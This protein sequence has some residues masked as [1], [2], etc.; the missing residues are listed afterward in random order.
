MVLVPHVI[1]QN[2]V[3]EG[4]RDFMVWSSL[5]PVTILP[6]L[7]VFHVTLQ[8]HMIKVEVLEPFKVSKHT[9]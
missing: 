4:S 3:I 2:K 6:Y 5:K 1:S 7:V 8:N 9:V